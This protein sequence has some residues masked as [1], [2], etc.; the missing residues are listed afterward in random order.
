MDLCHRKRVLHLCASITGLEWPPRR[1]TK[2]DDGEHEG[3]SVD[4]DKWPSG[5][6][7]LLLL[8]LLFLH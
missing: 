5:I 4:E 2:K 6:L 8:L 1:P 3:L 7:P